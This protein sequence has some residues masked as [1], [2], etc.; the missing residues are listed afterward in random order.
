M[1]HGDGVRLDSDHYTYDG[2]WKDDKRHG[3][4]H[5]AFPNGKIYDGQFVLGLRQG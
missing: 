4:G 5:E 3:Y 1:R 2:S